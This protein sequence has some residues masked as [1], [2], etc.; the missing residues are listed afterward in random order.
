MIKYLLSMILLCIPMLAMSADYIEGQDYEVIQGATP[1]AYTGGSV[2]V[3]EF[4]SYGCPWCYRL[5]AA[6]T[7]WVADKGKTIQFS[8]VP[9]VFNTGW[10]NYAKAYYLMDALSLGKP[11]HDRLFKAIIVE[12]QPLTRPQEM[13]AFFKKSGVDAALVDSVFSSSPSID[14]R[15][16][17]DAALMA[18]YQI[19][20]VPTLVVNQQYKTNLQMAK[21]ESRLFEIANAL[22]KKVK[23]GAP[24]EK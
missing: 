6:I 19:N 15:L 7:K 12:K 1:P 24:H 17:A 14:L 5:D 4:F 22:L 21:S 16:K 8:R 2:H 13:T 11:I 9:V 3:T 10:D 20:A 23:A 18:K